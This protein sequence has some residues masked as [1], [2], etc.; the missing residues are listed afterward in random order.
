MN[1]TKKY[2]LSANTR[3]RQQ[4]FTL[5][6]LM[7]VVGIMAV[8]SS[9]LIYS[10]GGY[11]KKEKIS[12]AQHTAVKVEMQNIRAALLAYKRDNFK[13]P[14]SLDRTSAVHVSFLFTEE[15]SMPS[16]DR[17]SDDT[18]TARLWDADY[19]RG[20][21]GPYLVGGD[22]GLVDIGDGLTLVD[23]QYSGVGTVHKVAVGA[24][25]L[26]HAIPDPFSALP[27][28]NGAD[29]P[30]ISN[31]CIENSANSSCLLDWRLVGQDN[32]EKPRS[33]LGR[34]Y[35]FFNLNDRDKAR[36]VS[37]GANGRYGGVG[38]SSV[39]DDG[40]CIDFVPGDHNHDHGDDQEDDHD[41][42]DEY[43]D[44]HSHGDD[45]DIIVCLY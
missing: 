21:R 32:Q 12:E 14:D 23:G 3:K 44:D 35:L 25:T 26:Q 22:T 24:L 37:M 20:W 40:S 7:V 31:L 18:N 41:H 27:V 11:S 34:P 15:F 10:E 28:A 9:V 13:F 2:P 29:R 33:R 30:S 16:E 1:K 17:S 6:E 38:D 42:Q 43:P 45:D 8:L 36:I 19:Q 5:L 39:N 4:G